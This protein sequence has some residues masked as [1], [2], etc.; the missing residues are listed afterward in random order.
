M[1]IVTMVRRSVLV[2]GASLAALAPRLVAQDAAD[3][4]WLAW[5]GCW[6]RGEKGQ[7]S[8][9]T[10]AVCVVP[11]DSGGVDM[12]AIA[13]GRVIY[14]ERIVAG[15]RAVDEAGCTGTETAQWSADGRRLFRSA[16]LECQG[17]ARHGLSQLFALVPDGSWLDV[18]GI[19]SEL[20]TA[21]RVLRYRELAS[22]DGIP[23]EIAG[24]LA[25][26]VGVAAARSSGRQPLTVEAVAEATRY[27]TSP[28]V[29]VWL[30]EE[31]QGFA[32][33]GGQLRSLARAGVPSDVIDVMVALS[34]P[35]IFQLAHNMEV[36]DLRAGAESAGLSNASY[37]YGMPLSNPD[38]NPD[39]YALGSYERAAALYCVD[40]RG[41]AYYP[42]GFRG[43]PLRSQGGW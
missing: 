1:R 3:P 33:N 7:V 35:R 20:G 25:N 30:A 16:S 39:L 27:V 23:A 37:V 36:T 26:V 11:S 12:V 18:Q 32:L 34:F 41:L 29:Q 10:R 40:P 17:G 13:A 22:L 43:G 6:E 24:R 21:I 38:C 28:I 9:E 19:G 15:E 31:K 8:A 2:L 4:N 14:S 5:L 42:A